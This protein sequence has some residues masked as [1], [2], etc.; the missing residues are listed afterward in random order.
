MSGTGDG[1]DH[2]RIPYD[3]IKFVKKLESQGYLT[4]SE[5]EFCDQRVALKQ[6]KFTQFD[7]IK[8]QL[9]AEILTISRFG[10]HPNLV[11]LLGFCDEKHSKII[12]VY[13]YVAG[14]NLGGTITERLT[15]IQR[16]EI[17]LGAAR[18]LCYLHTGVD[19]A[20]SGIVHGNIKF[21]NILLNSNANSSKF[22][23]KVSGFGFS[24]IHP[25]KRSETE[26]PKKESDV[27]N[28]G[29]VLLE[30]LCGAW[31]LPDTDDACRRFPVLELVPKKMKQ[32]KLR[33]TVD[34]HIRKEIRTEALDT[35][36][37]I[38]C[39]CVMENRDARPQWLKLLKN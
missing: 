4:V 27:Y 6:F 16:L 5:G 19:A 13:E 15:S 30:V 34:I 10:Q 32:N 18:G 14:G 12:L 39:Q 1:L 17:C 37:A 28:F 36:A 21:S 35:Y 9:L 23:A 3:K 11:A 31:E 29:V 22:E 2:L 26:K 24:K 8:P 20:T 7:N 38:A 33:D 25:V